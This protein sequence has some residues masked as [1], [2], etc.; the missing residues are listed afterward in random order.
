MAAMGPA[1]GMLGTVIGLILMLGN[2]S[3]IDS[4]GPNMAIALI[5]TLYGAMLANCVFLPLVE[6]LKTY[7][8][9]EILIK[10]LMLQGIMALQSG[11]NPRIVEQKL[12]VYLEPSIRVSASKDKK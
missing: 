2:M 9:K 5:T 12:F 7:S 3:D 11:D 6:K 4:L 8:R 10:E 1:Y